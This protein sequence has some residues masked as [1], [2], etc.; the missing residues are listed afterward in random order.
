MSLAAS[1]HAHAKAPCLSI[2]PLRRC[3]SARCRDAPANAR[4]LVSLRRDTLLLDVSPEKSP[5]VRSMSA[6]SLLTKQEDLDSLPR[7]RRALLENV[8]IQALR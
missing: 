1:T 8:P 6:A 3:G 2:R 4:S 5:T 7:S